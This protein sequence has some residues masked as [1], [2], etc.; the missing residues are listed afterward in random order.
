MNRGFSLWLDVLRVWATFVVVLSHLAYERFTRGDYQIVRDLNIGSDAVILF[1]VVS[2]F[3]IAYASGRD[4]DAGIYAFN[5]LT[6]LWSVM[7]PAILLTFVF[8]RI[9]FSIDHSAYP[10]RFFQPLGLGEMLLRGL[11]FSNEW[12]AFE[13]VRLGTNGPLWSLSYEAAYYL[14]F[15]IAVFMRGP[16]R[17]TLLLVVAALVGPRVLLLMPAW[18][19]GVWLWQHLSAR[20]HRLSMP[21]S[22]AACFALAGPL[23]Y[24]AALWAGL[25]G[26]LRGFTADL[27]APL[28]YRA[29]LVFSDEFIWNALIGI[30]AT[31]HLLGMARLL[32]A[33]QK[34]IP[35]IRWLAGASFSV[36]VTHYPALHLL[37]ALVPA[38]A[39]GHDMILLTGAIAVGLIFAQVFERRIGAIRALIAGFLPNRSPHKR[40]IAAE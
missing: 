14:A 38:D 15:A 6:R 31:L 19:M 2:G 20:N 17:W 30:F 33:K 29:V 27:M 5:R 40:P 26:M 1:F 16:R 36:Y 24:V 25:P 12:G 8:D 34:D 39:P 35:L 21:V 7:I 32:E 18:L 23:L 9:G 4:G 13:R 10:D 11:S 22:R 3:V 37:D 28:P